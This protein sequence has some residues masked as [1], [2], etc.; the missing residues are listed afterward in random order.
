LLEVPYKSHAHTSD[1]NNQFFLTNGK[2]RYPIKIFGSHNFQNISAAKELLKKIGISSEQF[3][4]AIPTFE[5]AAGRLE[6]IKEDGHTSIYKDFAHA[7]S[8]V[9]ATVKALKE[10]YPSRDLI[11]CFELHTYSSLN[12]KFIPQYKDSLKAAQVSV[13]YF[14]PEKMKAKNMEMLSAKEIKEAFNNPDV[15]VFEDAVKLEDFLLQQSWKNKNLLMMSSGNFGG[16]NI[17]ALADKIIP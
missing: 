10:V 3:F 11:A 14:N 2:E 8:K 7:P 15:L 1:N 17:A 13:V 6:K 4:E 12:K 16:I 5:G 9:K